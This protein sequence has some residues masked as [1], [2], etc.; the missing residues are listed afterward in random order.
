MEQKP[1]KTQDHTQDY[2]EVETQD[3]VEVETQDSEEWE[4]EDIKELEQAMGKRQ[5]ILWNVWD[6]VEDVSSMKQNLKKQK[7][8]EMD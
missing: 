8:K 3:Y 2:V 5:K 1:V 4:T 6:E 7:M